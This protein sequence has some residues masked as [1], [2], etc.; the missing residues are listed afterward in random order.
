MRELAVQEIAR[1]STG[2]GHSVGSLLEVGHDGRVLVFVSVPDGSEF[3]CWDV[4][5]GELVWRDEEG[6]SDCNDTA[7]VRRPGGGLSLVAATEDGVEW[8]DALTGRYRPELASEEG[9]VWAL[10][11][12]QLGGGPVL[13][14]AGNDGTVYQWD[15]NSGAAL[16]KPQFGVGS[17]SSAMAVGFVPLPSGEGVI[18][19]GD[20][21]GRLWRWDPVTGNPLGEPTAGHASKVRIIRALPPLATGR[22]LF[23]SSDQEGILQRW[24]AETGT[25]VGSPMETGTYVFTLAT[26]SMD[27]TDLLLAAG[28]DEM[29][30]AWDAETGE[31]IGLAAN[32][33]AVSGLTPRD[34]ATLLAT[35]TSRGEILV[36]EC[37]MSIE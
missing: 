7:L 10:N 31:P 23:V 35:S 34:G 25:P 20:D 12:G 30:R 1:I 32:G 37:S 16:E 11:T 9:T 2:F 22:S 13:L 24:D 3:Q 6:V 21:A 29:V 28:A 8:W 18:V 33:V 5:A 4:P 26:V 27:G 14:G 17:G 15:G 19:A 36:Y